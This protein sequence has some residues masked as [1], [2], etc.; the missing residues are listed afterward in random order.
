MRL[1]IAVAFFTLSIVIGVVPSATQQHKSEQHIGIKEYEAFHRVLHPLQHE[2]LPKKDFETIRKNADELLLKGNSIVDLGVPAGINE[3]N[4][5]RFESELQNFSS[6]LKSLVRNA[7]EGSD[8]QLKE[9]FD[10]VHDSF[11]LLASLLPQA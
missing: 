10:G 3:D 7:K 6:R 2:A 1:L 5:A 11:E 4:R 8:A 9:S